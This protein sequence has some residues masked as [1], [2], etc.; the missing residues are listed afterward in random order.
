M[1]LKDLG[2]TPDRDLVVTV[3]YA[4][5]EAD[6]LPLLARELIDVGVDV[7][8]TGGTAATRAAATVT[9]TIPIVFAGVGDPVATGLVA[10]LARPGGNVTGIATQH[11]DTER[12]RLELLRELVPQAREIGFIYN[13]NNPSSQL[14]LKEAKAGA[15]LL[16]LGFRAYPTADIAGIDAILSVLASRRDS[17]ILLAIDPFFYSSRRQ[18][19]DIMARHGMPA[20]YG[21]REFVADGGLA[22]FGPSLDEAATRAA[23]YV[24]KILRGVKPADLPVQQPTK[25]ELVVNLKTAKT[26][27]LTIPPSVLARADEVI[28]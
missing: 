26:L 5:G 20:M 6:R 11:P 27:G 17:A 8:F 10:S 12:K 7:L 13:P 4:S 16:S 25:F 23:Q 15:A 14:A 24:D 2:W 9:R 18:I 22:S 28:Q 1:T 21:A 3:R 19:V